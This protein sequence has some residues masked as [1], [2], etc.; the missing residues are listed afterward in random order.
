M[1][2]P[3]GQG[4]YGVHV[5]LGIVLVDVTGAGNDEG[6]RHHHEGE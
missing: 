6:G 3:A 1:T 5:V 4:D 2:G